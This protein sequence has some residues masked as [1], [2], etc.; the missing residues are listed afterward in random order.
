MKATP[1]DYYIYNFLWRFNHYIRIFTDFI[2]M[3]HLKMSPRYVVQTKDRR[4]SR[5][6]LLKKNLSCFLTDTTMIKTQRCDEHQPCRHLPG[7]VAETF[8]FILIF[9][10]VI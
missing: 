6:Y 10:I 1:S 4:L 7:K 9:F 8:C 5:V 2:K 3:K